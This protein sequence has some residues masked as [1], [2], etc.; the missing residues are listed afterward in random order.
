VSVN[1]LSQLRRDGGAFALASLARIRVSGADRLRYLN[2]QLSNDL[3]RLQ[4]GSAM[5]ALVLTARGKLCALVFV[6]QEN[7]AIMVEAEGVS[8]EDL[9][10]RL[11]RYAISDDVA[12]DLVSENESRGHIFGPAALGIE[13]LRIS[14]LGVEGVDVEGIPSGITLASPEEI[15]LLRIERG[16]PKWG[17]ELGEDTL[18]QEAGLE[19]AA[20]NFQK[21]C[22]VGQEVVSRIQSVGRVNRELAGLIGDFDP[23]RAAGLQTA[24]GAKAGT[25]TSAVFHPELGR[26]AGLGFASTRIADTTFVVVDETGACLGGAERSQ[27]PLVS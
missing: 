19:K 15:E 25:V 17:R 13:G 7:E 18:P 24:A 4:P 27:F 14:R 3:R 10:A 1:R 8:G 5:Q 11:E 23:A 9:M 2:G 12:F 21:G 16:I 22:Y 20:V 26:S 6:W